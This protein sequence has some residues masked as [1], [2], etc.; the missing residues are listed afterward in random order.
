MHRVASFLAL[1]A[2]AL[3]LAV[4]SVSYIAKHSEAGRGD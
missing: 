2:L 1:A 4:A 3:S